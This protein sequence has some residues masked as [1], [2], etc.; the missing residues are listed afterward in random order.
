MDQIE[1]RQPV[2]EA[3]RAGRAIRRI[4]VA[5]GAQAKGPLGEILALARERG[6]RVE[7]VPR[8]A[9]ERRATS[10]VHQGVIAEARAVRT[11]SWREGADAA[12]SAGRAPLLL[13]LDG[14]EDPRNLGALLRSAD[15]FGVDA[16]LIP[17]RRS[18]GLGAAAA[19]ASAGAIEHLAIDEVPNLERA[20]AACRGDGIWIVALAAEGAQDISDCVLLDEPVAI[21]VGAEGAGVSRLVRERADA[22]VRIPLAGA[23]AS[24]NASVAGAIALWE[25]T[26]RRRSPG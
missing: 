17:R 19:K 14:I 4:L 20:L 18:A 21:V 1:G 11:R 12:R 3:L 26:R 2:R 13:A 7:R 9:I 8:A 22:V 10:P 6:V 24:L 5:E 16:V 23:V 15:A 25:A